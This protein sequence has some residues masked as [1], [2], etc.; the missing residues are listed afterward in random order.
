MT[1][2]KRVDNLVASLPRDA[3]RFWN[4]LASSS[5]VDDVLCLYC[6]SISKGTSNKFSDIDVLV[7]EAQAVCTA[8]GHRTW[9]D[10]KMPSGL[11]VHTISER[12]LFSL[13]SSVV[14]WTKIYTG[15]SP[16]AERLTR[17]QARVSHHISAIP[18]ERLKFIM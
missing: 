13:D 7:V 11:S 10:R 3:K 2:T 5:Q 4:E 12:S 9:N 18:R 17:L 6:G 16:D 14:N 1:V 8:I 15:L